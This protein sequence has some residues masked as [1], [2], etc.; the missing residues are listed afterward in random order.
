MYYNKL[1]D[2]GSSISLVP[3]HR[4]IIKTKKD[5]KHNKNSSAPFDRV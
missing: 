4:R 2:L 5:K 3:P 1:C